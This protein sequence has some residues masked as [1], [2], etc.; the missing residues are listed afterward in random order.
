ME[1]TTSFNSLSP[2]SVDY[3]HLVFR[4]E[5]YPD[6]AENTRNGKLILGNLLD[7]LVTEFLYY[8]QNLWH[9]MEF[10][11]NIGANIEHVTFA[12]CEQY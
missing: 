5:C 3:A 10:T 8:F 7:Y 6:T 1:N 11:F 12:T 9:M 2:G 4:R